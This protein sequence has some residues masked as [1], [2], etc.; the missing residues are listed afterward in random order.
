MS[1][2][3]PALFHALPFFVMWLIL[4]YQNKQ[5]IAHK[6]QIQVIIRVIEKMAIGMDKLEANREVKLL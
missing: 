4:M 1:E 2:I 3:I 5:L 6:A